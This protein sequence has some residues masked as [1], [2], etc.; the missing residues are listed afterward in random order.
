MEFSKFT[1]ILTEECNY[2]C[3]Y[4]YQKRGEK[5][6]DVSTVENATDFFLPYLTDYS[7]ISFTGGEP[8]L[9]FDQIKK[10]V[11]YIQVKNRTFHKKIHYYITTNG[12]LING[13]ILEF[14]NQYKFSLVLSFDGFAQDISREKGSF[15]QIVSII[16]KILKSPYIDLET[17]SVFTP[18]TVRYLSKSI[19]YLMELGISNINIALS[20]IPPWDSSSLLR[21]KKELVSL[22][23]FILSFYKKTETIPLSS[24]RRNFR[25]GIFACAAGKNRMTL[26]PD[27]KLWGCYLFSEY[28]KGKE[29]ALEYRRYCFGELDSFIENHE[30]IYH[31]VL[32]NYSNLRMDKF[33]SEDSFCKKCPELEECGICPVD[34]AFSCSVIGKIPRWTC[35]IK[36]IFRREKK[37][38]WRELDTIE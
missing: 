13:D 5:K 20:K 7:N 27:G 12:S 2:S 25:K 31:K 34:A 10:A 11:D 30:K 21:L 14:L 28:F 9:A 6:V 36:K 1:F 24:F 17:N 16:E 26:A 32:A 8:L 15:K 38:F 18:A 19:Q 29:G 33:Y 35:E 37:L 22:K 3:S 4:C 23:E